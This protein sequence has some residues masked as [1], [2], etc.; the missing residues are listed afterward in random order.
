M[1]GLTSRSAHRGRPAAESSATRRLS[2]IKGRRHESGGLVVL[3]APTRSAKRVRCAR[4]TTP[5]SMT[6]RHRCQVIGRRAPAPGMRRASRRSTARPLPTSRSSAAAIPGCRP[7][8]IWRAI[9]VLQRACSKRGRSASAPRAAMA[10][11]AAWTRPSSLMRA[12]WRASAWR[13]PA[14]SFARN[15]R[16][17]SWSRRSGVTKASASMRKGRAP[18][19]SRTGRH[20]WPSSTPRL[21]SSSAMAAA[22]P[23]SGRGTS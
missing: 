10:G 22:Q 21:R 9:M 15:E 18:S 19:R 14:A 17:S 1:P 16:R 11:S 2:E 3:T 20:A 8:I 6:R 12:W 7:L 23:R 5:R 13:R 4:S